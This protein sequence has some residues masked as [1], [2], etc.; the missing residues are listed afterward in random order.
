MRVHVRGQ[1]AGLPRGDEALAGDR[2]SD[3]GSVY[4]RVINTTSGAGLL[5]HFGQSNYGPARQ[6][7]LALPRPS[8]WN[9][10]PSG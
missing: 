6:R 8:A 10:G 2:K 7:S 9:S 1:L 3:G 5:G 4:G